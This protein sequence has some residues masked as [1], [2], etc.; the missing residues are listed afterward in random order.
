M[1]ERDATKYREAGQEEKQ[2]EEKKGELAG[3][4]DQ[5]DGFWSPYQLRQSASLKVFL[6][7]LPSGKYYEGEAT[8]VATDGSLRLRRRD[9]EGETMGAGVVWHRGD[10]RKDRTAVSY[11][12]LTL[13]TILRV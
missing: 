13:P 1:W 6:K 10:A 11:T 5:L 2:V 12:H 4:E 8:V 9:K 3:E 7:A